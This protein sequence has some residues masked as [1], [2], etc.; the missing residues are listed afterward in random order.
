LLSEPPLV[1]PELFF[2]DATLGPVFVQCDQLD[3]ADLAESYSG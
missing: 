1:I 2:T 3:A